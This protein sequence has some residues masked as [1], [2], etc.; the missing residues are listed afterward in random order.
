[1]GNENKTGI[2]MVF[3]LLLAGAASAELTLPAGTCQNFTLFDEG[4]NSTLNETICAENATVVQNIT[5]SCPEVTMTM[6]ANSTRTLNNVTVTCLGNTTIQEVP[7]PF[8]APTNATLWANSTEVVNNATVTC[9]GN[10]TVVENI[11]QNVTYSCP[12]VSMT[13]LA[14]STRT[15]NNAT[16]TCTSNA[17]SVCSFSDS[18]T[19]GA[20][21]ILLQ[22]VS[23]LSVRIYGIPQSYCYEN[24]F[25]NLTGLQLYRS[26]RTNTTVVCNP[27]VE[28]RYND[29]PAQSAATPP[30][31]QACPVCLGTAE[32]PGNLSGPYVN[33]SVR[34]E[35]VTPNEAMLL[36]KGDGDAWCNSKVE[37]CAASITNL[38]QQLNGPQGC[39]VSL[40]AKSS[41]LQTLQ[42]SKDATKKEVQE[43]LWNPLMLAAAGAGIAIL[44]IIGLTLYKIWVD[45]RSRP[46]ENYPAAMDQLA[47]DKRMKDAQ[48]NPWQGA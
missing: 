34:T 39:Y 45:H 9:L 29:C 30:T 32:T 5:Y 4:T 20:S 42:D 24:A 1:M 18:V 10:L 46:P 11:T 3:L 33:V 19:P 23:G 17:S 31:C 26:D 47:E 35:N 2:S 37:V 8:C 12:E 38:D 15:I 13:M 28:T 40:Q 16:I 22:N 43:Q 7:V 36:L 44:I 21:D 27:T 41:A 14:N 48:D 6:Y 25:S